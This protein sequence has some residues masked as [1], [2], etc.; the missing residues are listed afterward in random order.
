MF[1][2]LLLGSVLGMTLVTFSPATNARVPSPPGFPSTQA[3]QGVQDILQG[4]VLI[5]QGVV[6]LLLGR[7]RVGETDILLGVA[8]VIEG[9]RILASEH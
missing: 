9:E 6:D 8:D 4:D 7:V 5:L 1:T 3:N 2:R